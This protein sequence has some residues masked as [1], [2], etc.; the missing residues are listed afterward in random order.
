ME[1]MV[2]TIKILTTEVIALKED[3][4]KKWEKKALG[5][6][7]KTQLS[8]PP[9]PP[10]RPAP[11][12]IHVGRSQSSKT[13]QSSSGVT[14]TSSRLPVIYDPSFLNRNLYMINI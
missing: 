11:Q 7:G 3:A 5:G 1:S 6:K 12:D 4:E 8:N 10:S 2:E 9:L 13:P 14:P